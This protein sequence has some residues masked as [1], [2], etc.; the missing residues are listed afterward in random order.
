MDADLDA[1]LRRARTRHGVLDLTDLDRF[2]VSRSARRSAVAHGWMELAA[3]GVY[4]V[5]GA[6]RTALQR[7]A[8]A[9]A[10]HRGAAIS[11]EASAALR[12]LPGFAH[13]QPVVT[14]EHGR[15][16]RS[17]VAVVRSTLLLPRSHV[18]RERG[19]VVTTVARTIFDLA[20]VV[21]PHRVAEAL[22]A[23]L[24]R[25]LC[26]LLQV[27]QVHFA[28]ARPGRRGTVVMRTMLEERGED[29]IAP[30]SL[31]ESRARALFAER[32]IP[33]PRF[34]VDLGDDDWIGRVDC[35]WDEAHLV[36]ELDGRR[37]HGG[38]S[39][40]DR[41]RRRDN[42]LMARGI[43]VLRFTWDDLA[44]RPDETVALVRSAL[45]SR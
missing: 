3:P 18:T 28:L 30:A 40:R 11:H 23:A 14:V 36:V 21:P 33:A 35:F 37:F 1:L 19:L 41:D 13:H 34:E 9:L 25:R 8:I 27:Q 12:N 29:W 44:H 10:F 17:P 6:P 45:A 7:C 39:A 2:G 4:V 32:G 20:G 38:A 16:R 31:L 26:T 15:N 42:R 43:R 5:A 24:A 22:D